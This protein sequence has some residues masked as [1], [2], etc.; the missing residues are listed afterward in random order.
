MAPF[1]G[2][3]Q[4][5]NFGVR[6]ASAAMPAPTKYPAIFDEDSPDH[7]IGRS[8]AKTAPGQAQGQLHEFGGILW[9]RQRPMALHTASFSALTTMVW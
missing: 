4:R 2:I 8:A 3:A 7:G 6:P 9:S 5:R 1:G